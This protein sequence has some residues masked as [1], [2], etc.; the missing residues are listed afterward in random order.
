MTAFIVLTFLVRLIGFFSVGTDAL[1]DISD[2]F[3]VGVTIET[4]SK[5]ILPAFF[6]VERR[7]T[8]DVFRLRGISGKT[9]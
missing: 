4:D 2:S 3:L 1:E 6:R 9:E 7:L 5:V 8:A